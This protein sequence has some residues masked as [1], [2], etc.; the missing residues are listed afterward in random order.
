MA[1]T[2]CSSGIGGLSD[3]PRSGRPRTLDHAA[4]VTATLTPTAKL[5]VSHWNSRL[6]AKQSGIS[7]AALARAWRDYGVQPWR[8]ET[9]SAT[10]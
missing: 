3:R 2:L 7:F 10:G 1:G 8:V 4:I 5:G 9:F 6:L